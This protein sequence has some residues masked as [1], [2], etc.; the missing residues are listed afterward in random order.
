MSEYMIIDGIQAEIN[1]EKNILEL[2]RKVGIEI[3]AFCYDPELSIYGACRM[4]MFEDE[5]GKLDA[6]CSCRP[7]AGMVIKTNTPK[8]RKYRKMILE[9]LLANHCRDCTTCH[10]SGK[11]KLQEFAYKFNIENV[12]FPNNSCTL[13]PDS[14]SNCILRNPGKCI[15][16][17]K[18]VRMC[19]EIKSVGAIDYAFRGSK[20]KIATAFDGDIKNS[21]CV[22]C[23]QCAA[24]CPTG[25]ITIRDDAD[26]VW[27]VLGNPEYEVSVQ[28]APAVRVGISKEFGFSEGEN[29]M[30]K[31]VTAL[32]EMGFE[33]VYDTNIGA[34]LTIIEE[35][36]EL[37]KRIKKGGKLP[38]FTS[39]CPAW[40]RFAEDKYPDLLDNI[41]TCR[42]PMQM[43]GSTVKAMYKG[44]KK[45]IHVAIMPCS[46]KKDE[47]RRAKFMDK[48]GNPIIDYVLSTQE[49]VRM[50]REHGIHFAQLK[51]DLPDVPFKEYTGA[52]V[53]FGASGGVMEA[54]LR[55]AVE[56]I[57]GEKLG[58]LNFEAVRG[59]EGV[60]EAEYDV[61]G[62]KVKVAVVSGLKNAAAICDKVRKGEADY[63]FIEIMSCPGG[64]VNGAGQPFVDAFTRSSTDYKGMR[65]KGLYDTDANMTSRKSHDNYAV[66]AL[67]DNFFGEVG[68]HKAHELLHTKYTPK[69]K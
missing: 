7:R 67:Y 35:S 18:C 21:P 27:K 10:M 16:C 68:G 2:A 17:G 45:H 34:D 15:L 48:D 30:G 1:G 33:K 29:V 13:S 65:A 24:V 42:S 66:T 40:I 3:P 52:G 43:L 8:L 46:A 22:G 14:S 38:M 26:L 58:N 41:S 31:L 12:R 61:K 25:A 54:A 37:I 11:C 19:N 28:I 59:M 50:I 55:T 4:C 57:T 60:K 23:G 63:Q 44:E 6:A 64:C 51:E 20:M 9:L 32:R 53:I 39:C 36:N 69:N 62:L 49:V 47:A 5:R 56:T